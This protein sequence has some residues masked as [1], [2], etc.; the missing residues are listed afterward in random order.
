[1]STETHNI[2]LPFTTSHAFLIG[3]NAYQHL[4]PL[5][6]AVND[7]KVVAERDEIYADGYELSPYQG[8]AHVAAGLFDNAGGMT[9]V[10]ELY[11]DKRP[12]GYAFAGDLHGMTKAEV[13]A[14]FSGE[15]DQA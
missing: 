9:L 3:I 5:S 13:E 6:T 14:F 2:E 1:M 8:V 4:T 11:V 7:T 15:G 10:G 12:S